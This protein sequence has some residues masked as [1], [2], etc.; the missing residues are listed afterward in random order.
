MRHQRDQNRLSGQAPVHRRHRALHGNKIVV[1][2]EEGQLQRHVIEDAMLNGHA[3]PGD[4]DGDG[5]DDHRRLAQGVS[6]HYFTAGESVI[7]PW[8]R[9]T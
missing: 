2:T 7:Q 6:T 9:R 8:I 4:P 1:Y 3:L 5:R